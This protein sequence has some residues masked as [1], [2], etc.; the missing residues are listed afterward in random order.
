MQRV[1]FDVSLAGLRSD[2][3]S[4]WYSRSNQEA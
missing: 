2:L 3:W 4:V 1:N